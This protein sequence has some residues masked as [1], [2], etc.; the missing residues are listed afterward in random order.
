[1]SENAGISEQQKEGLNNYV[2]STPPIINIILWGDVNDDLLQILSPETVDACLD[3]L[4]I[5]N[6]VP[7]STEQTIL[8]RGIRTASVPL[9]SS[10]LMSSSPDIGTAVPYVGTQYGHL[11]RIIVPAGCRIIYP[12]NY[13]VFNSYDN[14]DEAILLLGTLTPI[15]YSND[16]EDNE[17]DTGSRVIPITTYEYA[18]LPNAVELATE[19][20]IM[21]QKSIFPDYVRQMITDEDYEEGEWEKR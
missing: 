20:L 21:F 6:I 2:N 9:V 8:Y 7:L 1:M 16:E 3:L 18:E 19:K 12:A 14:G 10:G 4:T 15:M 17:Y 5:F 13:N 11:I